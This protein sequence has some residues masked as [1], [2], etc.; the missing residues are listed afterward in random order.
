MKKAGACPVPSPS[1]RS[2]HGRDTERGNA[3]QIGTIT[4]IDS[5]GRIS[6]QIAG[7]VVYAQILSGGGQRGD[8]VEGY[9]KPGLCSWMITQHRRMIVDVE[10][11]ATIGMA[12]LA[13]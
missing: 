11:T 9:M 10:S 3:M 4:H 13:G 6:V 2:A 1:R 12:L 7:R 5:R 8:Q